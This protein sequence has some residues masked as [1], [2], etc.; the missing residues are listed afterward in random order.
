MV[1]STTL[2]NKKLGQGLD[3]EA[4]CPNW[5]Q[6]WR[7]AELQTTARPVYFKKGLGVKGLGFRGLGFRE[8]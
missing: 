8:V 6:M 3:A 5:H 7:I 1:T 4:V 2:L